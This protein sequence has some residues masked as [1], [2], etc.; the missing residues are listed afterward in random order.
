MDVVAKLPQIHAVTGCDTTSFLHGV[1]KIK[2][3]KKFLNGKEKFR[4]Q[5]RQLKML[6]S[7]FKL[8]TTLDKKK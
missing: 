5:K 8:F 2:V 3:L 7:L 4:L 6:K 1:D